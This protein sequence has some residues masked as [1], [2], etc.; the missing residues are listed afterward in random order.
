MSREII[1]Q[2]RLNKEVIYE[3]YVCGRDSTTNYMAN[4]VI[5]YCQGHNT[6]DCELALNWGWGS[7]DYEHQ[8]L[9]QIKERLSEYELQDKKEIDKTKSYA[10]DLRLA[11]RNAQTVEAFD[12]FTKRIDDTEQWIEDNDFSRAASLKDM[13]TKAEDKLNARPAFVGDYEQ[14]A[15]EL[16]IIWSE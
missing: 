6:D 7:T 2:A 9:A 3:D 16:V 8:T 5:K 13:L 1:I 15:K 12:Q 11:R 14:L 4:L 10:Q